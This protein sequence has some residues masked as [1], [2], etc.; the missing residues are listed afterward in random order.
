MSSRTSNQTQHCIETVSGTHGSLGY[1]VLTLASPAVR[2]LLHVAFLGG[3]AP[4]IR[5]RL[6]IETSALANIMSI[7]RESSQGECRRWVV[8]ESLGKER[9]EGEERA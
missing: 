4:T 7:L 5:E 8:S 3:K 9:L 1:E 6:R 2:P